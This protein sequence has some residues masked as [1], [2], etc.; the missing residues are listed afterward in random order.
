M[1]DMADYLLEVSMDAYEECRGDGL[2]CHRVVCRYCD[3][4]GLHWRDTED[5]WRLFDSNSGKHHCKKQQ[6]AEL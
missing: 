5:G 1:G 4:S 3:E 2:L 6:K